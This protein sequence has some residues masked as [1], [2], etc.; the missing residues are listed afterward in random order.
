M[1]NSWVVEEIWIVR[2]LPLYVSLCGKSLSL[3]LPTLPSS[4]RPRTE[5]CA[6]LEPLLP[7]QILCGFATTCNNNDV[8]NSQSWK[9]CA[10]LLLCSPSSSSSHPHHHLSQSLTPSCTRT[11]R[12][13]NRHTARQYANS[14]CGRRR[15]AEI[16]TCAHCSE[17]TQQIAQPTP[18]SFWTFFVQV[19]EFRTAY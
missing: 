4:N 10:P 2:Q 1:V 13:F 9:P 12:C 14:P 7:I 11:L 16:V 8:Q 6:G 18:K 15:C 19:K 17:K 3:S 5:A